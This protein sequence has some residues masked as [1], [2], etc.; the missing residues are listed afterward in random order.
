MFNSYLIRIKDDLKTIL[1]HSLYLIPITTIPPLTEEIFINLIEF[2]YVTIYLN[3]RR[4]IEKKNNRKKERRPCTHFFWNTSR[5]D[6]GKIIYH[7]RYRPST[8]FS[9]RFIKISLS[10]RNLSQLKNPWKE[11]ES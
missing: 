4:I 9:N 2:E 8:Y 3:A 1:L 6:I 7:L 11:N 5:R 10:A